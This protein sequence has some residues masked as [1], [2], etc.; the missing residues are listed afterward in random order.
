V[1][2]LTLRSW[3]AAAMVILLPCIGEAAGLGRLAILSSLGEP[4][5]A[6][7]ELISVQKDELAT[8]AARLAPPEAYR[9]A[10]LQ[11]NTAL[12]G[13]RL[14]VERRPNG[15]PFI[16]VISSRAVNEPFIDL[17]VELSWASGRIMREYTALIDPPGFAAPPSAVQAPAAV[18][19]APAPRPAP[20]VVQPQPAPVTA[21]RPGVVAPAPE[22]GPIKRGETLSGVAS[23]VKPEG[24]SLEQMLIGIY[25]RNPDAFEQNMNRLKTGRI[26]RIPEK[27]ELAAV[28]QTEAV[29]EV[30]VQVTEWNAYKQRLAGEAQPSR[31]GG[32]ASGRITTRVEEKAAAES[33]DVVRLSKAEPSAAQAKGLSPADRVRA[34]EEEAVARER[35]LAEAKERITLLEKTIKD[36]Q[37]LLELKSPGLAAAQ[38]QPAGAPEIAKPA[39]A[40]PEPATPAAGAPPAAPEAAKPTPE[41]A[42]AASKVE[43]A[44]PADE[45]PKPAPKPAPK[46]KPATPPP[47]PPPSLL[48]TLLEP[49]YLAIA[50]GVLAV[51][52]GIAYVFK[53]RR[54][55]TAEAAFPA[56]HAPVFGKDPLGEEA[57]ES[58]MNTTVLA[59]TAAG[60]AA[61]GVAAAE[62]EPAVSPAAFDEVDALAEA[63]IYITYGRDAQAEEI[64]K[65]AL[66]KDPAREDVHLKLLEI[67][68][69]RKDKSGFGSAVQG[70]A[71]LTG[72]QGANWAKAAAM[73]Y[74]LEPGNPL[75][76]AGRDV[77][78]AVDAPAESPGGADLDFDL[79]VDTPSTSE[80]APAAEPEPV[81]F[82]PAPAPVQD[83]PPPVPE[84]AEPL[85]PDFMLEVPGAAPGTATDIALDLPGTGGKGAIGGDIAFDLP[86][87]TGAATDI[88][89]DSR[90]ATDSNVIDFNIELPSLTE[91]AAS[92][93]P[94]GAPALDVPAAAGDPGL[95]FNLDLGNISLDLDEQPKAADASSGEKDGHWYDV[96]Q[97]FD[98]A[99]AYQEMGNKEGAREIL[100]EVLAEG[101]AEQQA[102]AKKALE[103]LG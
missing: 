33:R 30:R 89:L 13:L 76:E 70:L 48:D 88:A 81:D 12:M 71:G 55:Q 45:Q 65:E 11:Y 43:D 4:L 10:N 79:G 18:V 66:L 92:T 85:M 60:A 52:G 84:A 99:K 102:E 101:D 19:S 51:L 5:N 49:L 74:A 53:R 25:R 27:E 98:L 36:Q 26:L 40:K 23:A 15:Q 95:D 31:D 67:Y 39:P 75:Y 103:D 1:R 41:A 86:E 50:G 69:A 44:K 72:K 62:P 96:Q 7:I 78:L 73:G 29:R 35:A 16:K 17:L 64:L 61:V 100:A 83:G 91:P 3:L 34:L 2:T 90:P 22:Y 42:A 20:A 82:S 28:P 57:A 6:E 9:Q 32:G 54:R 80:A 93:T 24:V 59:A 47:P 87:I 63:E 46:P 77:A 38:Q 58:S 68:A 37:R 8:L 14:T 21:P 94:P 56:K 97:K